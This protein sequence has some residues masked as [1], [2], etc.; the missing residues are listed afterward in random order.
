MRN[1]SGPKPELSVSCLFSFTASA[2]VS[3]FFGLMGLCCVITSGCITF[4]H[5]RK[6]LRRERRAQ[7][8]VEVMRASTFT[9]SPHLYWLNTQRHY[10]I[11]ADINIGPSP[12]VNN[13]E[14]KLQ[15]PDCLWETD[16]PEGRVYGLRGS[17][18]RAVTP[19]AMQA[20]LVV[21]QQLLS[22]QL[23]QC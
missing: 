19:V 8:W 10:G 23:P 21:S 4:L 16:T 22:N 14:M 20:A 15:T 2:W 18:P 1:S 11:N 13:M 6:K 12:A 17:S 5:W 3:L 9:Y 7:H